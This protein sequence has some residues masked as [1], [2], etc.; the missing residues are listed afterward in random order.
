MHV[1]GTNDPREAGLNRAADTRRAQGASEARK[2]R[3]APGRGEES[4][5]V[6]TDGSDRIAQVVDAVRQGLSTRAQ[7]IEEQRE[8]LL[9]RADDPAAIRRA[10]ERLVDAE[11]G[12]D[13]GDEAAG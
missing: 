7:S 3:G 2:H 11:R 1:R 13:A 8:E 6:Q 9:R 10:A 5:R 4:D 12:L